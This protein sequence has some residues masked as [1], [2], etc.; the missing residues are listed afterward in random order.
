MSIA[1]FTNLLMKVDLYLDT[2]FNGFGGP[3]LSM[4]LVSKEGHS[5]YEVLEF[6]GN[7]DSW[8]AKNVV[9]KFMKSPVNCKTFQLNLE[10]FL[11]SF[12][13]INVI[14]DWPEDIAHFC[15]SLIIGP[16]MRMKLP[17]VLTFQIDFNLPNTA[18][19][20]KVPHN[21]LEDAK[22]LIP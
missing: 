4:A 3:L 11:N 20:S 12:S 16:G 7:Y 1:N 9:P 15:N 10:N 5:F 8:V 19:A 18:Y 13:E 22:S 6:S 17:D 14:A 2:E 21:A